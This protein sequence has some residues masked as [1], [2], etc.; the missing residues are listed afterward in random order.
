[1]SP[2]YSTQ[3]VRSN[4]LLAYR[5]SA[6]G[7]QHGLGSSDAASPVFIPHYTN[8]YEGSVLFRINTAHSLFHIQA[9][10][11]LLLAAIVEG[12]QAEF[13]TYLLA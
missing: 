12:R 8:L 7:T 3:I 1:M 6:E 11:P 2:H 13:S 10:L 4:E 5:Q 9:S